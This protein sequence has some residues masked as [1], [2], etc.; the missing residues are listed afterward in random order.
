MANLI[1]TLVVEIDLMDKYL[2]KGIFSPSAY[3]IALDEFNPSKLSPKISLDKIN[4]IPLN[5]NGISL[6]NN[7]TDNL[8]YIEIQLKEIKNIILEKYTQDIIKIQNILLKYD[9]KINNNFSINKILNK[10]EINDIKLERNQKIKENQ[11]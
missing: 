11:K 9:I 8:F 10:K 3:I 2:L 6:I 1:T 5:N 4:F 7:K